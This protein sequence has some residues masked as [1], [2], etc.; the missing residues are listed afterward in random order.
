M[1]IV[2]PTPPT[3]PRTYTSEPSGS[4]GTRPH[5]TSPRFGVTSTAVPTTVTNMTPTSAVMT[6][7]RTAYRP[8]QT[9]ANPARPQSIAQYRTERNGNSAFSGSPDADIA[10]APYTKPHTAAYAP[11]Y[12]SAHLPRVRQP[13]RMVC[14]D[15]RCQRPTASPSASLN[16]VPMTTA[17]RSV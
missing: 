10:V 16:A 5:A 6:F 8:N 3:R 12:H 17:H 11:K 13:D 2:P 4:R 9:S 15:V 7:S 1:V 14:P